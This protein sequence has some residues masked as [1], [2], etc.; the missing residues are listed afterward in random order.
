MPQAT[1]VSTRNPF[2]K[3]SSASA[4]INQ[5]IKCQI[6]KKNI[7][8]KKLHLI[9]CITNDFLMG[10]FKNSFFSRRII[11]RLF[12]SFNYSGFDFPLIQ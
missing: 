10:G 2:E 7:S 4:Q 3:F 6:Q 9:M 11:Y 12:S 8:A 5:S 1:D